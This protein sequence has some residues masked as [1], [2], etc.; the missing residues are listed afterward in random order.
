MQ[1]GI[2]EAAIIEYYEERAAMLEHE[3]RIGRVEAE[4]LAL[5]ATVR[6]FDLDGAT[7][8]RILGGE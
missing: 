6:K 2:D 7:V 5:A 4:E 3:A 8:S 1:N